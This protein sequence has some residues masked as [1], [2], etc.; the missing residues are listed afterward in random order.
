MIGNKLDGFKKGSYPIF[1]EGWAAT[2]LQYINKAIL[3]YFSAFA[4]S[5]SICSIKSLDLP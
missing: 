5:L 4:V 3:K 2:G 1:P